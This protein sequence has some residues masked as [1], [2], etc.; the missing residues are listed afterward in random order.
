MR[1]LSPAVVIVSEAYLTGIGSDSLTCNASTA[2]ASMVVRKKG[3]AQK[4]TCWVRRYIE[5][6]FGTDTVWPE[7]TQRLASKAAF[8][9]I[10]TGHTEGREIFLWC[11]A[12][13]SPVQW[14]SLKS[15][16]GA[17]RHYQAKP[18]NQKKRITIDHEAW[19]Y[20]TTL[21]K[22]DGFTICKIF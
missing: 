3:F 7:E 9:M 1:F 21:A 10:N 22:R 19:L 2:G 13:L 12:W 18:G 5:R 6:K 17:W 14:N 16:L 8:E 4:E 20:L 11:R 15:S